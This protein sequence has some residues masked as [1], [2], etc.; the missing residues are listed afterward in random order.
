[1]DIEPVLTATLR[2]W[3]REAFCWGQRDCLM[4]VLDYGH[5]LTGVDVGA[6]W[7]GS[8]SSFDEGRVLFTAAGFVRLGAVI[9]ASLELVGFKR[10]QQPQRGDVVAVR[11]D[12]D[13]VGG[14]YLGD[15]VAMRLGTAGVMETRIVPSRLA[16]VWRP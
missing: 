4:G 3:R 11:I 10:V 7:R 12:G 1:M 8:Y 5:E 9:S 15:F 14:L 2:R 6:R 16:G 13:E